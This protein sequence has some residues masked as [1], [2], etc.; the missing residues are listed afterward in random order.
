MTPTK[1]QRILIALLAVTSIATTTLIAIRVLNRHRYQPTIPQVAL[2]EAVVNNNPA[3]GPPVLRQLPSF[4][5]TD[6][7]GQPFGQKQLQGKV[8]IADFVFTRCAGPCPMMTSQMAQLQIRLNEHPN[9]Q[10]IRLVTFSVDP[11][12]D[13]PA[14]LQEYARLAHAD[15]QLWRFLTGRREEVWQLVKSGFALPVADAPD[16]TQMPIMHSQKFVLID[17]TGRV[18]G[19]YDALETPGQQKLWDDLHRVLDE[20]HTQKL[21]ASPE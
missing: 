5:L 7:S 19:F 15:P 4:T 18:R 8:W 20:R 10:D 9:R 12:H 17:A 3:N 11:E 16:N 14:V 13:T 6:Q 1:T 2:Q 21:S